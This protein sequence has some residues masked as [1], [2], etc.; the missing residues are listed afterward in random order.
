M[1]TLWRAAILAAIAMMIAAPAWGHPKG[2]RPVLV[3]ARTSTGFDVN[4]IVA[5]DDMSAVGEELKFGPVLPT[6]FGD[7]REYQEYIANRLTIKP[8]IGE[9]E[10]TVL[11]VS[12][13][14]TGFATRISLDCG[15]QVE[16][17]SMTSRLLLDISDEYIHMYQIET[18]AGVQRG[19]L[20]A[21]EDDVSIDFRAEVPP[22]PEEP[23]DG[24]GRL[25]GLIRGEGGVSIFLALAIALVLGAVHGLTPGHGKTLTAA[26]I[27]G[28]HG[29]MRDASVLAGVVALAH[30]ASTLVLAAIASGVDKF[31]PEQIVPWFEGATALIAAIVGIALLRGATL[32]GHSHPEHEGTPGRRLPLGQLV[33]IGLV[34][35]L[36]PGPE[37]FAVGFLA[38]ALGKVAL[39]LLLIAAFSIGLG[40]VVFAVATLAVY[41]GNKISHG[42]RAER[43]ARQVGGI[44]FLLVAAFLAARLVS[45]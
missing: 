34:G 20:S 12:E 4:W 30:G 44:V 28:T 23:E 7:R 16:A 14:A 37:A 8:A 32:H 10:S 24:L 17:A 19:A 2:Q 21:K 42:A 41:A 29:T 31:A 27:T 13:V 39:A 40:V 26:Y 45:G 5:A 38:V 33:A 3:V 18:P 25:E 1:R 11:G 9:C 6:S 43:I 15:R 22:A 36:I 35:G